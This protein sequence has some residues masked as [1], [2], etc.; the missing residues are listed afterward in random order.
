MSRIPNAGPTCLDVITCCAEPGNMWHQGVMLSWQSKRPDRGLAL[1]TSDADV[2]ALLRP[3]LVSEPPRLSASPACRAS[4][5]WRGSTCRHVPDTR[6]GRAGARAQ[7]G[8]CDQ[9]CGAA[10]RHRASGAAVA[11][12]GGRRGQRHAAVAR[13]A[14]RACR[15]TRRHTAESGSARD[16]PCACETEDVHLSCTV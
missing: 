12:P 10:A 9:A 14:P 5:L 16:W 8:G 1:G 7:G 11:R 15:A 3:H 4:W 6:L 2:F 13:G